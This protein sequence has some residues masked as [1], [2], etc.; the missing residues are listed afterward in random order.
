MYVGECN[1]THRAI[2]ESTHDGASGAS[3]GLAAEARLG[4]GRLQHHAERSAELP[5]GPKMPML[6]SS[7]DVFSASAS[8]FASVSLVEARAISGAPAP[9]ALPVHGASLQGM[10]TLDCVCEVESVSKEER[11]SRSRGK[12]TRALSRRC[13]RCASVDGVSVSIDVKLSH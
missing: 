2:F 5:A 13:Y 3:K 6:S 12:V 11:A 9:L 4:S 10:V 7:F 8:A 1:P